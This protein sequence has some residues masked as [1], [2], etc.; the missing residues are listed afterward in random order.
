M[1]SAGRRPQVRGAV[2]G[3]RG[4]SARRSSMGP[5]EQE[6]ASPVPSSLR[7]VAP[8]T[9]PGGLRFV[10]GLLRLSGKG[11]SLLL[12]V[13]IPRMGHASGRLDAAHRRRVAQERDEHWSDGPNHSGASVPRV[14]SIPGVMRG[15]AP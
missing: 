6:A 4:P 10:G 5:R 8:G 2:R 14:D 9:L 12:V 1:G 13:S 11:P 3:A 15:A 7:G